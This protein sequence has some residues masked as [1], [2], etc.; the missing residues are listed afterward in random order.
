MVKHN[1]LINQR[2]DIYKYIH[3]LMIKNFQIITSHKNIIM[4][5]TIK[6]QL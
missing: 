4:I 5:L 2:E 3:T 1:N 6:I